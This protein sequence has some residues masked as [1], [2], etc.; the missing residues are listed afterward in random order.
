[1]SGKA[2]ASLHFSTFGASVYIKQE[3]RQEAQDWVINQTKRA[4]DNANGYESCKN[5][6][7]EYAIQF[8]LIVL[9]ATHLSFI[10]HVF[11]SCKMS[12]VVPREKETVLL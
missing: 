12:K 7:E 10:L 8:P 9:G 5:E 6:I 1:M 4:S 3:N 2:V 11:Y